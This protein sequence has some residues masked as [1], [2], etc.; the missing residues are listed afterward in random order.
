MEGTSQAL[1]A[2][3]LR[4][5]RIGVLTQLLVLGALLAYVLIPSGSVV[6]EDATLYLA[7]LVVG[8]AGAIAVSL[9]PW[10]RLFQTSAG[11]WF[12]Y[13]WSVLDIVLI[14]ILV[15]LTG[16]DASP[17]FL[18]YGFTS[19]FFAASYPPR[20]QAGLLLCT[21]VLYLGTIALVDDHIVLA[22]L[23][24]RYSI[25][26]L[27]TFITSF[28]SR[29]LIA[30]NAS[31][32]AEVE[33]HKA[34]EARLRRS[35]AELAEAQEIARLGSWTWDIATNRVTWSDGM[36]DLYGLERHEFAGRYED[37]IAHL[38]DEDRERMD[39]AVR[40][41][42]QEETPFSFEYRIFRSDGEVRTH[43]ARGNIEVANG[44]PLR[45][46]GTALDVTERK[47]NEANERRMHELQV[48]QQQAIEINDN[49][50]QGLVVATYAL[51]AQDH[52]RAKSAVKKTLA[53][54]RSI[55]SKLLD[56]DALQPGDLVRSES[57]QVTTDDEE[58][59]AR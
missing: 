33:R 13:A 14:S 36:F 28:L 1:I 29:E 55:V 52:A 15:G 18:L 46:V 5:V 49:V 6:F 57:A 42:V 30:Q 25:L 31:L 54:A 35:Q 48:K 20:A 27:L 22:T 9:L 38:H 43:Q 44:E 58:A 41:A 34:T 3:R 45:M 21:F 8:A 47:R 59:S 7:T 2:Y 23:V 10:P 32:E 4:T 56:V 53:A 24:V 17:L 26:A 51:D 16:G 50:V 37:V 19:V 12:M 40:R 39:A 11:M